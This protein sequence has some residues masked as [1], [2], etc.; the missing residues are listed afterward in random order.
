MT[1]AVQKEIL[2]SHLAT[3]YEDDMLPFQREY[4]SVPAL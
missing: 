3:F 1:P 4:I 2:F